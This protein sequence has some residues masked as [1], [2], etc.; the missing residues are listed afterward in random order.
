VPSRNQLSTGSDIVHNVATIGGSPCR[1]AVRWVDAN[2]AASTGHR[3]GALLHGLP[4]LGQPPPRPELTV[5]PHGTGDVAAAHL[6]RASLPA[7]GV[8]IV[9][10]HHVTSVGR[11]ITDIARSSSTPA[12]VVTADAA[13]YRNLVSAEALAETLHAC[14]RWPGARRAAR[15]LALTDAAAESPFESVSRLALRWLRLPAPRL[16]ASVRDRYGRFVGRVELR[17]RLA[18]AFRRGDER[19]RLNLPRSWS[20]GIGRTR[21]QAGKP[22]PDCATLPRL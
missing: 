1:G 7:S 18:D 6:H 20:A 11:T 13:L 9:R 14:R 19:R 2:A 8:A 12:V 21:S 3:A 22:G 15:S 5:P 16:Q 4:L 17:D 10:G